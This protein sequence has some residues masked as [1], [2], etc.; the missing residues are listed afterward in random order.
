MEPSDGSG[1]RSDS[2]RDDVTAFE[3]PSGDPSLEPPSHETEE[4]RDTDRK[5]GCLP[6]VASTRRECISQRHSV[7]R[8]S[9]EVQKCV[10]TDRSP[11]RMPPE[12]R[13]N[14]RR[15]EEYGR[16]AEDCRPSELGG[17]N[18]HGFPYV[19]SPLDGGGLASGSPGQ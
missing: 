18:S 15:D 19:R 6:L 8:M 9:H 3:L 16:R 1:E 17:S 11:L 4:S 2:G 10:R 13:G 12:R 7:A 14:D 5:N